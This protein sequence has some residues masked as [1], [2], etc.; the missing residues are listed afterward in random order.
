MPALIDKSEK[1]FPRTE[2]DCLIEEFLEHLEI[3]RHSSP[4]T[5][6]NYRHYLNRFSHWL[7]KNSS[8]A[9]PSSLDPQIIKK[10]RVFL[11]RYTGK[12]GKSLSIIT[13]SYHVIA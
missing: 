1:E 9:K 8:K 4:L 13:Q 7:K 5:I 6:R 12:N 2:I 11:A 10:Y 3:E